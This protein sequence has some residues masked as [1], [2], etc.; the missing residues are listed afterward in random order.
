MHFLHEQF[1]QWISVDD[2][3]KFMS[4]AVFLNDIQQFFFF[5]FSELK[6]IKSLPIN[7][8]INEFDLVYFIAWHFLFKS[9]SG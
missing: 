6:F 2:L 1:S 3:I 4:F 9:S 8:D 5:F 7:R